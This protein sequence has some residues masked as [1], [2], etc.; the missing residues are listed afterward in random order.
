M[1]G[2][3][4]AIAILSTLCFAAKIRVAESKGSSLLSTTPF[5]SSRWLSGR[6]QE[7]K[8]GQDGS[9]IRLKDLLAVKGG[10]EEGTGKSEK[11]KGLCVGIDLGTTYRCNRHSLPSPD[12]NLLLPLTLIIWCL[13]PNISLTM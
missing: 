9:I 4:T 11:I 6:G 8:A 7:K 1:L 10:A 3:R 12:V 13:Y 5:H 2:F